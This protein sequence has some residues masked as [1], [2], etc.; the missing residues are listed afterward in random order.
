MSA[1]YTYLAWQ[2]PII[3][4]NEKLVLLMLADHA[5]MNG[6]SSIYLQDVCHLCSLSVMGLATILKALAD[7]HLLEKISVDFRYHPT[8]QKQ[9]EIHSFRLLLSTDDAHFN[10]DLT[11]AMI[12]LPVIEHPQN[13]YLSATK[14]QDQYGSEHSSMSAHSDAYHSMEPQRLQQPNVPPH[15][16]NSQYGNSHTIS[17]H[18]L[19][20]AEIPTW[21]ERAFKFSGINN[22]HLVVW[23]AF[24]LWH[25]DRANAIMTVSRIESKLQ[26]WLTNEKRYEKQN[27][28]RLPPTGN[29]EKTATNGYKR[30]LSPSEQFRQQLIQQ[31]KKPN[32]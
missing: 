14:Q 10:S 24:V 29:A 2:R 19:N 8:N 7:Q 26:S 1:K 5:D 21:A 11:S 9:V 22:D 31:G 4:P 30:K 17:T 28:S 15:S 32:F 20:D 12:S 23:R 6:V 18:E 3:N 13:A 16:N 25:R 27:P